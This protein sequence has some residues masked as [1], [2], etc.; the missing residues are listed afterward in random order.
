MSQE[1]SNNDRWQAAIPAESHREGISWLVIEHD[2]A[3]TGGYF[4]LEHEGPSG[5][6]KYDSWHETLD[7][8]HK[9]AQWR[10]GVTPDQWQQIG[11]TRSR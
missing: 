3:D 8:A 9:Q 1:L 7:V 6:C 11:S 4:L 10:W 5:P 2:P